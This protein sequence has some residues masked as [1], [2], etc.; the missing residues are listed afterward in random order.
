MLDFQLGEDNNVKLHHLNK[1]KEKKSGKDILTIIFDNRINLLKQNLTDS[2]KK[3]IVDNSH[4]I[5]NQAVK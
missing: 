2:Q 5:N 3:I 4:L 1:T